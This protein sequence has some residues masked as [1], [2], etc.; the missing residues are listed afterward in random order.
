MSNLY[1]KCPD[2][3]INQIRLSLAANILVKNRVFQEAKQEWVINNHNLVEFEKF[4]NELPFLKFDKVDN[5]Y[6]ATESF[7]SLTRSLYNSKESFLKVLK[8]SYSF[9]IL[10]DNFKKLFYT[11]SQLYDLKNCIGV[12][13]RTGCK[14]AL[15]DLDETRYKPLNQN[16]IIDYLKTK[17]NKIYL[18]TDNKETQDKFLNIF[19]DRIIYFEKI[20]QGEEN[21]GVK[22]DRN[23]VKRYTGDLH[24]VADF[25]LLQECKQFIGSNESSFSILIKYIRENQEDFPVKGIL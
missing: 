4:F 6:I 8:E 16:E 21:F 22:Y 13:A 3:F 17:K 2:G 24:V 10:K 14:T 12:H 5:D 11:F 23:L 20:N 9:L 15:L 18:A 7:E 25:Y 19:K 1:I